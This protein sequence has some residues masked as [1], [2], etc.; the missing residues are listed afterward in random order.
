[1]ISVMFISFAVRQFFVNAVDC[2]S[3]PAEPFGDCVNVIA[4]VLL[5][6]LF[7]IVSPLIDSFTLE[8]ALC[9]S[10]VFIFADN[11]CILFEKKKTNFIHL[12]SHGD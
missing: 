1:M 6:L 5:A 3:P 10:R 4:A 12:P 9:Q 2:L 11:I 8:K 7:N